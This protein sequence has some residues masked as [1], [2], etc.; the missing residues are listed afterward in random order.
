M[1]IRLPLEGV[2]VLDASRVLAGPFCTMLLSDLGAEIVKVEDPERGDE[3]RNYQ[4]MIGKESSYFLSVNRNKDVVFLNLKDEADRQRLYSLVKKSD[5]FIHNFLPGVE[6]KLGVRYV[7]IRSKNRKILYVTISGYGRIGRRSDLPG[8]DILMQGESGLMSVTGRDEKNLARVGNSTVDIYAGYL[9]ATTILAYLLSGSLSKRRRSVK[10]D[11][12]LIGSALY[13]MP[14][15]FGSF[16]ATGKDPKP[17][18][19]AHPGIVP[20]QPFETKDRTIM[21]AV[22]NN[23]HWEKFCNAIGRKDLLRDKRFLTN[24]LRVENREQL[25]P[26]LKTVMMKRGMEQWLRLFRK[27]SVPAAPINKISDVMRD[28]EIARFVD[29]KRVRGKRM[30]FP[31]LP[32][33]VNEE[34]IY[35]YRKDPPEF[36]K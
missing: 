31:K 35:S 12:P 1:T 32:V 6:E 36:R 30:L 4:P 19:T 18:G 21:I 29:R 22:A 17:I 27:T 9:C 11:I 2:R 5:V 34:M 8:Y 14:F 20:Y 3:T 7:T 13:S 25:I 24:E 15:L 28:E 26:I 16:A 23:N 10:L 33:T